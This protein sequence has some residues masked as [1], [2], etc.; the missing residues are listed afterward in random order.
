MVILQSIKDQQHKLKSK[1]IDLF[2]KLTYKKIRKKIQEKLKRNSLKK[3]R[4]SEEATRKLQVEQLLAQLI[5]EKM[6]SYNDDLLTKTYKN[7]V[8]QHEL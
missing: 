1:S 3:V 4:F 5:G 6:Q 2:E 8:S 7:I